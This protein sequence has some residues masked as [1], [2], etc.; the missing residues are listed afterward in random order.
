[1]V[2]E[3]MKRSPDKRHIQTHGSL[4]ELKIAQVHMISHRWPLW[5]I[6]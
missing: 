6:L 3:K 2:T 1:M 5:R 4:I